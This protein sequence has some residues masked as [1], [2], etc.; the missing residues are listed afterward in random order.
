MGRKLKIKKEHRN[1]INRNTIA[2]S[3]ITDHRLRYDYEFDWTNVNILDTE[4][5]LN[6]RLTSE[7]FFKLQKNSINFQSDIECLNRAYVDI[8][9]KY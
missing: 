9:N 1:H 3:V 8:L 5:Y 4:R 6:K 2:Q 7:M